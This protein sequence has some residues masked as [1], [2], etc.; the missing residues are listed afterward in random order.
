MTDPG[1]W[2]PAGSGAPPCVEVPPPVGGDAW[3]SGLE[4]ALPEEFGGAGVPWGRASGRS[5]ICGRPG[6]PPTFSVS[7]VPG[8]SGP[9]ARTSTVALPTDRRSTL[10]GR[11]AS[12]FARSSV[13]GSRRRVSP[14]D[15]TVREAASV[16]IAPTM[17]TAPVFN[18]N[19]VRESPEQDPSTYGIMR[20]VLPIDTDQG[21]VCA[22]LAHYSQ[23]EMP[24]FKES[25]E[26][27]GPTE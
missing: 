7:S 25:R 23:L 24:T 11:L 19:R 4:G 18:S 20:V 10:L 6:S 12:T 3:G 5:W 2:P 13:P 8:G 21:A 15:L 16:A 27:A 17:E 26:C 9:L 1:A 22:A 14:P